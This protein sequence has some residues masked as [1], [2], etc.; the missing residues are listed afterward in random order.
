MA[1][2]QNDNDEGDASL[3]SADLSLVYRPPRS[4][5]RQFLW[6]WRMFF[7]STFALSMFEGWEK[8]LI[9]AS[10]PRLEDDVFS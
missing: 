4:T 7:E 2:K 10:S 9:G 6:R 8:I 3:F 1:T 5:L